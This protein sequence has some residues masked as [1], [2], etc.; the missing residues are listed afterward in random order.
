MGTGIVSEVSAD[1]GVV[2][3]ADF[4]LGAGCSVGAYAFIGPGCV[5]EDN[6]QIGARATVLAPEPTSD[7]AAQRLLVQSGATIGAGAVVCGANVIGR[8]ARIEPGAVVTSDVPPHAVVAGNP[9]HVT[10]YVS[11]AAGGAPGRPIEMVHAPKEVGAVVLPNGVSVIRFPEVIDL[12]GQ[13]TFGEVDGQLPFAVDRFFLVYGVA[14]QELRGEHAHRRCHQL[15]IATTG[16]V[17]VLTDNGSELIEVR[18]DEPNIG[19]YLPP[20]VWGV[21]FRHTADAVLMVLA[22]DRYDADDYIRDYD[23]FIREVS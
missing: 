1:P 23:E 4:V 5:A 20:M 21:Q 10:G 14:S 9:S 2:A 12:R 17:S 3:P 18:I 13:L 6:V 19:V 11:A 22:S 15:I 16:A 8:G 7:V